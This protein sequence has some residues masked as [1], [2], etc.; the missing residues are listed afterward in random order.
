M[1]KFI[2]S[3]QQENLS[4]KVY[5]FISFY[6]RTLEILTMEDQRIKSLCKKIYKDHKQALDLI[7]EYVGETEFEESARKFISSIN[8]EEI[9]V[10][11]KSAW[12]IPHNIESLLSKVAEE[13]WCAGYPISFWYTV[14][15]GKLGIIIEVGPFQDSTV[16][17]RFLNHL[18]EN[19]F[20]IH[21]RSFKP[22]AKY[23]RIFSKYSKF[24]DWDNK[25]NI[26]QKMDDL[27]NKSASKAVANLEKACASFEWSSV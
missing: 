12:F 7:Y 3:I 6:L 5:D 9:W 4:P 2:T 25:E 10:N 18:K 16:R 24:K 15:K 20:T 21:D 26:I 17:H 22:G 13:S 8:A 27:L 23:T 1:L 14:Q 11:G 19:D